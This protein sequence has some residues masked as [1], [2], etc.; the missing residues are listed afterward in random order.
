MSDEEILEVINNVH[1]LAKSALSE[2]KKR[3]IRMK[4]DAHELAEL[5]YDIYQDEKH[6]P[7][8]K[9]GEQT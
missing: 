3:R 5:I 8:S 4:Q 7:G 2:A 6:K 1:L 9:N